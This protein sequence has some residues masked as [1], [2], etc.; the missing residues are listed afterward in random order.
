[1]SVVFASHIETASFASAG[2]SGIVGGNPPVFSRT[3]ASPSANSIS[4]MAN[5][6][7]PPSSL[8]SARLAS[9]KLAISPVISDKFPSLI[10]A[11]VYELSFSNALAK[12]FFAASEF[13]FLSCNAPRLK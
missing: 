3:L 13:P 5:A 12:H 4:K 11:L 1:M 8:E 6:S 2:P 9:S 7:R 10:A